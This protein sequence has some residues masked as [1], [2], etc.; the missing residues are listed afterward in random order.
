QVDYADTTTNED[1]LQQL[2]GYDAGA[3]RPITPNSAFNALREARD[4]YGAD[5]VAFVRRYREPEQSGCGIAWLLG[6]NGSGIDASRDAEFGYAVISDGEDLDEGDGFSYFCSDFS[7]AHE[8]GH[9]M[10][11]AH[12]QEDAAGRA[13]A[14]SYSYGYRETSPS[15]FFTIMAY[16]LGD[17]QLEIPHFANP[18]VRYQNRVTGTANADNVRSMNLTMPI[19]ANFRATVVPLPNRKSDFNKDGVS[20]ILWRNT[21]DG[22]NTI[23]LSANNG[24]QQAVATV[25]NKAWRVFGIGDF[26]GDGTADILWR[27]TS[28]GQNTIYL[29]GKNTT[30]RT[31]ATV[32]LA[33][34]IVGVGDFNGD[35]LSDVLW[36]N[37]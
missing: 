13:G 35:G 5:L 9:L 30:Q 17:A 27:N 10:G 16:P 34:Q 28:N 23:W 37:P 11:Q 29:G 36:R 1:A 20:D 15:G 25:G 6:M 3:G 4:E 32:G 24:T 21:S 2:T 33:W 19:V 18:S 22:R 8:F 7:L 14:H 12:N 31:V 26:D